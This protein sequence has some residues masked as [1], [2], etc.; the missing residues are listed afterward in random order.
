MHIIMIIGAVIGHE[1]THCFD[2][3][4]S[5]Y[6]FEG[7]LKLVGEES[8]EKFNEMTKYFEDEYNKFKVNGKNVMEN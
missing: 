1:L 5:K 3:Q 7:N 6:D 8:R 2:D 4:G